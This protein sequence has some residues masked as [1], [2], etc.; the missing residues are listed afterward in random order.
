MSKKFL[1]L[2]LS[3]LMVLSIAVALPVAAESGDSQ[4]ACAHSY[5]ATG[6]CSICG[7]YD[8]IA[9]PVES[10]PTYGAT[11]TS[12]SAITT[13]KPA[14]NAATGKLEA[15]EGGAITVIP[16]L[17][18]GTDYSVLANAPLVISF[19]LMLDEIFVNNASGTIPYPLLTLIGSAEYP[20]L[21]L[22]SL[23]ASSG[24]VEVVIDKTG[25][26]DRLPTGTYGWVGG[27]RDS[28]IYSMK[29]GE[30]YRFVV[31]YDPAAKLA[32]I[33]INGEYVGVCV[34][35]NISENMT[36]EYKLRFGRGSLTVSP[37]SNVPYFFGFALDNISAGVYDTLSDAY[38]ALPVNQIFSLRYDRWQTGHTVTNN[39]YRPTHAKGVKAYIGSFENFFGASNTSY[40]TDENGSVYATL[41]SSGAARKFAL[42]TT[43]NG[44]K[45]DLSG[46]RYEI[47]VRFALDSSAIGNAGDLVRLYRGSDVRW[48]LVSFSS[49]GELE[50]HKKALYNKSGEKLSFVTTVTN[51][52][53]QET[54][55]LRVVVDEGNGTY[56]VYVNGSIAYYRDGSKF[57]PLVDF[58]LI[59]AKT[60]T[61][62]NTLAYDYLQLFAGKI[63]A[64]LEE[65]AV[66]LI[67]DDDIAFVGSQSRNSDKGAAKDTFDLRFVFGVDNLYMG[68][69][70]FR[71]AAYKNGAQ[72]GDPQ[73]L[74]TSTVYKALNATSGKL[75]ASQCP[76]GE[77]L[78]AF[79][80]VGIEETVASDTYMFKVTPYTEND[81]V[82]DYCGAT[83][84]VYYNGLGQVTTVENNG[85]A[86]STFVPTLR[87]IV[88]SDVHISTTTAK[89]AAHFTTAV[90]QIAAYANDSSRN[91]GY[92]G[93][94]AVALSGDITN[95][96]TTA[97]FEAAKAVFDAAL[98]EGTQL[99]ITT[100]NHDYGN[101]LVDGTRYTDVTIAEAF[102]ADF[103]RIFGV[104]ASQDIVINGYHFVTV[105]SFGKSPD[106][107]K[108][109]HD[110]SNETVEWFA[111]TMDKINTD[112][113][114]PV[115]VFQHVGNY[116]TMVGTSADTYGSNSSVAM[117]EVA[118]QY[119]NL[120]VF[121]GHTHV[122]INDECSIYQ[123]DYTAIN[124]GGL[125][126]AAYPTNGGKDK[127][128]TVSGSKPY[129]RAV[130]VV[131]ADAYGRVRVR[132]WHI[133]KNGFFGEEWMIDSYNKDEFVYTADR[134]N[135]E[136]LF[137]AENATLTVSKDSETSVSVSFL[138]VPE[139]SLTARAYEVTV[140]DTTGVVA[141]QY[142]SYP[143]F[144]DNFTTAI[145]VTVNGLVAGTEYTVSV[146][147]ANPLYSMDVTTE[148]TL[149]SAPLTKTFTMA[150]SSTTPEIPENPADPTP[151]DMPEIIGFTIDEKGITASAGSMLTPT[152][153]P[154]V[155][156][157][158]LSFNGTADNLVYFNY[159]G[160]NDAINALEG[161]FTL[162]T[163]V[164][165]DDLP[166]TG[167][168]ASLVGSMHN[169]NG[170]RLEIAN[171]TS[172]GSSFTFSIYPT[173]GDVVNFT[174]SC[175]MGTYYHV[176]VAFDGTGIMMYVN[177][178]AV[179]E[180]PVAFSG[181]KLHSKSGFHKIYLGAD[182]NKDGKDEAHSNCTIA[183]FAMFSGAMTEAEVAAR[184]ATFSAQQ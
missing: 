159:A 12:N 106:N 59:G 154:V 180:A 143:Y 129:P 47:R 69:I 5:S 83:Q 33:Y 51:G 120:I 145:K 158:A 133:E 183:H 135:A 177:G 121:S 24:S 46:K 109:G 23:D 160:N 128:I 49:N 100:G 125:S 103:E 14:Y 68:R 43:S 98:P 44:D 52:I 119:S 161:A 122:A 86:D 39:N 10:N 95:K 57:K 54:T 74:T 167:K 163:Y 130:Y 67:P 8:W 58:P 84:I 127:P 4:E 41:S 36:E 102:R 182:V 79:K 172:K 7:A 18:S 92:A 63:G 140:S 178:E 61:D 134:F 136:D 117:S 155:K 71:V 132:M 40:A 137:F 80:I 77:Y 149:F 104:S 1:A 148:G 62:N 105:D 147:A 174:K 48:A 31:L 30:E 88:T 176:V 32:S 81:G 157:N 165:V 150:G 168:T 15:P 101:G 21:S 89:E 94:D 99:I 34:M 181:L 110:Y 66:T 19:D 114:K 151:V 126:G 53:P 56:S 27:I 25:N 2:V 153:T 118:S 144:A 141:Q 78:T 142:I 97:E 42:S 131:E 64:V 171:T 11:T 156:E 28:S 16:N 38:N 82:K 17:V 90:Q 60:F 65:A 113:D 73:Y 116:E 87:F 45:F 111:D 170:F 85:A 139:E 37:Y 3:I 152:G 179:A 184:A 146:R 138:P 55:D 162:E 35:D 75:H 112:P 76:E 50:A 108:Y 173:E 91:G 96:G 26:Q 70:G 123:E 164:R 124:T 115:F 13:S 166:D 9:C 29:R 107:S 6:K 20:I 72:V 22:G 169:G 175:E 93:L